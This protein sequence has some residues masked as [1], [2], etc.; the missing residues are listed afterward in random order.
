MQSHVHSG[1][2]KGFRSSVS[3]TRMKTKYTYLI[4]SQEKS[5]QWKWK[6][7]VRVGVGN[8]FFCKRPSSKY[9]RLCGP[10][11]VRNNDSSL[12]LQL[13]GSQRQHI[14]KWAWLCPNKTLLRNVAC[15]LYLAQG[16]CLLTPELEESFRNK[17][18]KIYRFCPMYQK[19]AVQFLEFF[20]QLG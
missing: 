19:T 20:S 5:K 9:F 10:F 12:P 1:N 11:D 7:Y 3:G 2:D 17:I 13:G 18:V 15:R 4:T 6:E 16:R 14:N 8:F